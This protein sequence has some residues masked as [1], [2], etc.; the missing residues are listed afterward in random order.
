M[1]RYASV[2]TVAAALIVCTTATVTFRDD[3]K[4]ASGRTN[5][6]VSRPGELDASAQGR[7]LRDG[8]GLLDLIG[9]GTGPE[10][11]P[12]IGRA[13]EYCLNGDLAECFKSRALSSLDD[14]FHKDVYVLNENAR[15]IRLPDLRAKAL[16]ED[17]EFSSAPREEDTDWEQFTKFL[18][19]KA[20]KFLKTT[21]I[22]LKFP[23]E[24]TAD[25]RYSPRFIED[26]ASEVDILEDKHDTKFCK[27][28][29]EVNVGC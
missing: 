27:Y 2:L 8:K 11:D 6:T 19:R 22:E 23:A 1:A 14:F 5:L 16:G 20:E 17:F 12:Y 29:N 3:D 28:K 21:A 13:N 15:V 26:I 10:T 24:E 25:G 18:M 9:L 4:P 7:A